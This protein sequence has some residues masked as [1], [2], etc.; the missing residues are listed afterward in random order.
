MKEKSHYDGST[1][2]GFLKELARE[3]PTL[4]AGG[5]AEALVGA[6]VE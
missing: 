6:M 4:P 3:I 1:I 2:R 5:C